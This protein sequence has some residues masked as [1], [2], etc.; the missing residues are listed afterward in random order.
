MLTRD[1]AMCCAHAAIALRPDWT[2][3]QVLNVL[4]DDRVRPRQFRHV[5]VALAWIAADEDTKSPGRLFAHGDWWEAARPKRAEVS[6]PT[7]RPYDPT[8]CRTCGYTADDHRNAGSTLADHDY[9]PAHTARRTMP[10]ADVRA[11]L[12][13]AFTP[14]TEES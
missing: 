4:R 11:A 1:E 8:G 10:P 9:E 14:T 13:A 7:F 6:A 12:N 3:D 2:V 5:A